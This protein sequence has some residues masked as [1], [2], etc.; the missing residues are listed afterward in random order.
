M[1]DLE[2]D[3]DAAISDLPPTM[4]DLE[5]DVNPVM[6]DH[7]S[8]PDGAEDE[9]QDMSGQPSLLEDFEA[10]V[11]QEE[12]GK[13]SMWKGL[14]EMR[15]VEPFQPIIQRMER[16]ERE[17]Q[18]EPVN[19]DL[20]VSVKCEQMKQEMADLQSANAKKGWKEGVDLDKVFLPLFPK[21]MEGNDREMYRKDREMDL[22]PLSVD[23]EDDMPYFSDIQ[24]LSGNETEDEELDD[25]YK[26][27]GL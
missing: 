14:M 12:Q 23:K 8:F 26:L 22:L 2:G 15:D 19:P 25:L 13:R 10:K 11:K 24:S 18:D 6:W 16:M 3:M 9:E 27:Y 20:D 7:V 4:L 17:K 21:D 5:A 1:S